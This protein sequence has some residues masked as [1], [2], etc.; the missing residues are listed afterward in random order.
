MSLAPTTAMV[1]AAGLGTRMRPLTLTKPKPLIAVAGQTML[2]RA[3]DRLAEAGVTRA[4]VNLHYLP[5]V[6]RSHL[7]SRQGRPEIVLSDETGLLLETGGGVKHA[8]PLLGDKPF[9]ALN[10]DMVWTDRTTPALTRLA[11]AWNPARM[12]ALLLLTPR[13]TAFGYEGKGDFN[14]DGDRP[15]RRGSD[16][17]APYVFSG[18]QILSPSL[19]VDTPDG[20]WS[21]N[22]VY[23]TALAQ[24]RLGAVVHDGGWFH[25]G[26]PE[27]VAPASQQIAAWESS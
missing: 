9:Y 25:V 22:R 3:L 26:T 2:D 8:L 7:A 21:L 15:L 1:L 11:Q 10:A 5:D 4:V 13:D 17:A 18:L 27:A 23:D 14:L 12:D 19:F 16:P 6:M 24:G 20:A